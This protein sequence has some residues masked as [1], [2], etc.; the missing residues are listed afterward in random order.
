MKKSLGPGT[1]IYTHPVLIVGTYCADGKPNIMAASW[2]GICCSK[3]PCVAVSMRKAT[4]S[5]GNIRATG[6]FTINIP[7][8]SQV[9]A[10]DYAG[11]A[12]GRDADKFKAAGLNPVRSE[13]VN[14]PCVSEFPFTLECRLI[15]EIEI[16]L[17]TQFIGEILDMKADEDVLGPEGQPMIEKVRPFVY[18]SGGD[19]AYFGVGRRLGRAFSAG[20]EL[21]K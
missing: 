3:P 2:G 18:A 19:G 6:A 17:H 16:G 5:Y 14:A 7:S 9:I 20:K 15:K 11:M 10:A 12:S 8:E 1:T 4:L 13:L 21:M